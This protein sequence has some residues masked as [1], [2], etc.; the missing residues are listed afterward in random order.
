MIVMTRWSLRDLTAQVIKAAAQRGGEE[1]RVIEF[2]A[3]FPDDKPL[4]PEFW[5]QKELLALRPEILCR[6]H[7]S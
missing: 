1:W 6:G 3:L 2:P 7:S 4:W 5:S